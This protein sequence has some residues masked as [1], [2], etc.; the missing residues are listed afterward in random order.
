MA[1]IF[2]LSASSY[3]YGYLESKVGFATIA[4]PDLAVDGGRWR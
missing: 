3:A 2:F 1:F 4:T